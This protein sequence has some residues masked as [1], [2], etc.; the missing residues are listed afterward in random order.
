MHASDYSIM[1]GVDLSIHSLK[2]SDSITKYLLF[3]NRLL[4]G[5]SYLNGKLYNY[6]LSLLMFLSGAC[7]GASKVLVT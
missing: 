7:D 4:G 6:F 5:D 2:T 1:H 3:K